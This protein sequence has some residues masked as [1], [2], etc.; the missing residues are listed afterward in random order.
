[1]KLDPSEVKVAEAKPSGL[2]EKIL[3]YN[4]GADPGMI[5]LVERL[6]VLNP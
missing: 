3:K 4:S 5:E 2:R 1:M 6:C